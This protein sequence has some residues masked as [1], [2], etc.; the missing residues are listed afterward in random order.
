MRHVFI[1]FCFLLSACAEAQPIDPMTITFATLNTAGGAG[2]SYDTSAKRAEQVEFL[3]RSGALLIGLQEVNGLQAARETLGTL[4]DAGTIIFAPEYEEES[5]DG[6]A[7]WVSNK[8]T[9]GEHWAVHLPW[10]TNDWPRVAVFAEISTGSKT[11]VVATTHLSTISA[12]WRATQLRELIEYPP[13]VLLGDFNGKAD[14]IQGVIDTEIARVQALNKKY[15]LKPG[16]E[17]LRLF[18]LHPAGDWNGIDN[19][20]WTLNSFSHPDPTLDVSDHPYAF[21]ATSKL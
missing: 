9:L 20:F 21:V 5:T 16:P 3:K 7:L 2:D 13:D 8:L 6:N 1:A 19:I 12:E 10:G 18:A 14:E 11:L 4:A 17:F 15:D